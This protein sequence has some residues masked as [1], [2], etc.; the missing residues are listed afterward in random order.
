MQGNNI[1]LTYLSDDL[2]EVKSVFGRLSEGGDVAQELQE[3]FWSKCYGSLPVQN[4]SPRSIFNAP[5]G[6]CYRHLC[7]HAVAGADRTLSHLRTSAAGGY[8][9]SI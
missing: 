5:G 4:Q 8:P 9:R 7:H 2:D 6:Q 1:S 3:T